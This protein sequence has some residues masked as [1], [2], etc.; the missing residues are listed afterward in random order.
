[1]WTLGEEWVAL[2][3]MV[4]AWVTRKFMAMIVLPGFRAITQDW[5]LAAGLQNSG[6]AAGTSLMISPRCPLGAYSRY[7]NRS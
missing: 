6:I 3:R 1:M 7:W 4:S 2:H 5:I